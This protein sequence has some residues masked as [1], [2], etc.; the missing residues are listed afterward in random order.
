MSIKPKERGGVVQCL[1][2]GLP[3]NIYMD[4]PSAQQV[5]DPCKQHHSRDLQQTINLH[6]QWWIEYTSEAVGRHNSLVSG[7]RSQARDERE[8]A[9]DLEAKLDD[10]SA[11]VQKNYRDAP[12]GDLQTWVQSETVKAA[13]SRMR[14]A[15]RSR[16]AVMVAVWQLDQLHKD[17][18][19]RGTCACGK[20]E[21][22][23]RDRAALTPVLTALTSW[24]NRELERLKVG[25]EHGLP[26]DHPEVMKRSNRS[27]S[28]V[29]RN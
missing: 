10:L 9:A 14:G 3:R 24:E 17:G 8:K 6:R 4:A 23:C 20:P 5:C 16:D 19:T 11:A 7:L 1:C 12:L 15:Y 29:F 28:S 18:R 26:S 27:Y 25:K 22:K 13:E 21:A 2:C